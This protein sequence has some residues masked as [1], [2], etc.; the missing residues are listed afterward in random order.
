MTDADLTGVPEQSCPLCLAL[1]AAAPG[2]AF[3][4]AEQVAAVSDKYPSADGHTLVLPRRHV[5]RVLDLTD[6]EYVALWR[7]VRRELQRLEANA[8]DGYTIGINDGL[9]AGQT[10]AHLHVH[11]IPRND[12]D[13][14]DPKGGIRWVLP[15]TADYWSR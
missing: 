12:G 4:G 3:G 7:L 15:A 1:P 8:P 13:T 2:A 6:D 9:A 10:I 14:P 11:V 5:G